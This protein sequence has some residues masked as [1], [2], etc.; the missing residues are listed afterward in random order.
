MYVCQREEV[1]FFF[2][3]WQIAAN[4]TLY[5]ELRKDDNVTIK[6]TSQR[7][8]WVKNII[9]LSWSLWSVV[10]SVISNVDLSDVFLIITDQAFQTEVNV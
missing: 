1:F 8:Y 5:S 9:I 4:H 7:E 6:N 2:F 3:F 10:L